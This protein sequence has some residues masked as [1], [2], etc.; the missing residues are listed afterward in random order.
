M[1]YAICGHKGLVVVQADDHS[2]HFL[3]YLKN[4]KIYQRTS[5]FYGYILINTQCDVIDVS[6]RSL[7]E[8]NHANLMT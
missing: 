2:T 7:T 5:M 3:Q 8:F 6:R 4:A 1:E